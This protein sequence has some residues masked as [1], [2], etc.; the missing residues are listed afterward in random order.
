MYDNFERHLENQIGNQLLLAKDARYSLDNLCCEIIKTI[1]GFLLKNKQSDDE[2]LDRNLVSTLRRIHIFTFF[3]LGS[4]ALGHSRKDN[5]TADFV[6]V[7]RLVKTDRSSIL[8]DDL[9]LRCILCALSC[10]LGLSKYTQALFPLEKRFDNKTAYLLF[11]E[12]QSGVSMR[13]F[14]EEIQLLDQDPSAF[15][16]SMPIL[17][18]ASI[19]RILKNHEHRRPFFNKLNCYLKLWR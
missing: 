2:K 7:Y 16:I 1:E 18:Y 13:L 15:T 14:A 6:L 12:Q 3:P 19:D 5:P 4:F 8:R 11:V 9:I 10:Q 17:H